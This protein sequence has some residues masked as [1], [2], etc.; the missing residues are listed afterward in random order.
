[1]ANIKVENLTV[2]FQLA[3]NK[4]IITALDKFSATFENGKISVI[5]G[6]SGSGKSTLLKSIIGS[7]L[8]NGNIYINGV[9][10]EKMSIQEKNMSYVS[11]E[12]GLYPQMSVYDNIAFP[13]T[14][15][16]APVDEIETRVKEIAATLGIERFLSRKP[17]ELSIG[18][19]QKVAFARAFIKKSDIYLFDEPFSNLDKPI[20]DELRILLKDLIK[21]QDATVI[22]VT[23]ES[24]D[25]FRLADRAYILEEG[26][27]IFEGTPKQIINCKDKRVRGYFWCF[28][29]MKF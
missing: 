2:K 23:H 10:S 12:F 17:K 26:K 24:T 13:L 25:V 29:L 15:I 18:Q 6:K 19:R 22:I 16:K 7:V 9:D 28:T 27:L 1:M 4:S 11:Q 3:K 20:A 14:M 5:L 8:I 21:S